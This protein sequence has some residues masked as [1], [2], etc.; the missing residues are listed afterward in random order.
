VSSVLLTL[1]SGPLY[2][3]LGP[4]GF[5]VMAALCALAAPLAL[6]LKLPRDRE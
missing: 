6:T 3:R 5:W 4:A 2:G 1:I